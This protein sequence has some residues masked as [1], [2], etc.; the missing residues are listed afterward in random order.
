MGTAAGLGAGSEAGDEAGRAG[1]PP[2]GRVV[3]LYRY[4][5]KGFSPEELAEVS[6][7]PGDGV[8]G[9]RMF[10]LARP[11]TEFTEDEPVFLPKTRFVML[12]K[13]EAIARI[14][15]CYDS[16]AG[17]LA[18]GL[19]TPGGQV[20]A[21]LTSPAGRAVFEEF[22]QSQLGPGLGGRPR[23]VAARRHHRFTDAGGAGEAFMHAVSVINLASVRD[24]AE[25]IGQPVDPLR[26]RGNIYVDGIRPWAELDWTGQEFTL[27]AARV[28]VLARTPRCA[29][30]TVNPDTG[31]RDIR[32][33]K[34][35]SSHYGH[36]D[37]GIYVT[38]L[39]G[40]TLRPGTSL[41]PPGGYEEALPCES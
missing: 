4:P 12:Q 33:L 32:I 25:R 16:A 38:V 2:P 35:L 17:T 36:T 28:R 30:T 39:T 8:P 23:L 26:F 13:D 40:A 6:L 22:V 1:S 10:A 27:G 34:E 11:G 7:T 37:C 29:A 24:L 9:D 3:R 20:P 41:T 14:R 5:V 21:D 18:F 31:D 15:T 19:G